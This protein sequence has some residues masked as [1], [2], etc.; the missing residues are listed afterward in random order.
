MSSTT[1]SKT[2]FVEKLR[3]TV[4]VAQEPKS[5]LRQKTQG[6]SNYTKATEK[7]GPPQDPNESVRMN[8]GM[9]IMGG[10]RRKSK[11][12][13]YRRRKTQKRYKKNR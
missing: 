8:V 9:Q 4:N 1:E 6:I 3:N 11:K 12:S 5:K 10:K 7:T 13:Y 2:K